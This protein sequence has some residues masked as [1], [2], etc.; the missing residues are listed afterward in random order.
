M[1]MLFTI[2]AFVV[3]LGILITVHEFGHFWVARRLGVKVLRFSIGFGRPLLRVQ[4]DAEATEYVL[5]AI[6]LGGYV[7]M[8]DEREGEVPSGQLHLAFNRQPLW[9]RVAIVAAGPVFNL[10]FAVLAYW[11]VFIGGDLGLRPV[12]AEVTPDSIAAEAGFE[13][14]DELLRVGDRD[15]PT[16]ESALFAFAAQAMDG[17]D[18]A[19][20]V[21]GEDGLE[22]DRLIHS[23]LLSGLEESPDLM[24][25]LG[26]S[27]RRP[28]IPAVIGEL[29]AGEA[30]ERAG[31]QVGDRILSANGTRVRDWHHWVELVRASPGI[32]L[33]VEVQRGSE[34]RRI[35]V[36]PQSTE[37][38]G[39]RIGRIGAAV[40]R[41]E[42]MTDDYLVTV[43]YGPLEALG[44][45]THKTFDMAHLMLKV[46]G[47]MLVGRASV[48]N[49]SGPITIAEAA[50]RSASYGLDPFLKFL[51]VV[52]VS[53]GVLNLLPIP[54][55]DGGHLLYFFI[56]WVKGSP[57]SE[58]AQIQGQ[59]LGIMILAALMTLAFYVDLSRLLS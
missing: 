54:V 51:A 19:V 3:A 10:V 16:W 53:L 11:L 9:R 57:M 2:A 32:P 5:A 58:T 20:R 52:S 15:S 22:R 45:A 21:R 6:P 14:G 27:P 25:K 50:G 43:S 12:V 23:D 7:K 24:G 28:E 1:D 37:S 26:L 48:D 41:H 13:P 42:E 36:T 29:V 35:T 39:E 38:N 31:L 44:V 17:R 18:L 47:R 30:A 56:E 8:L 40:E 49:L 34:R 55:L 59:K 4:R 33:D 46:M